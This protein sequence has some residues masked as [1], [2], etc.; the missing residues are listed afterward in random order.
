M[1][2]KNQKKENDDELILQFTDEDG[3]IEKFIFLD[4]V[5]L[6]GAEYAVLLPD[7]KGAE[8]PESVYIFEVIEELDSDTDTYVGLSDQAL[9][10][11]VYAV[12]CEKHKDDYNFI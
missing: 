10:D 6:D 2:K 8:E 3:N 7:K 4:S 5:E 9:V 12:F 1:S 11:R